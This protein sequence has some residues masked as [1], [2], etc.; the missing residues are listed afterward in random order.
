MNN[1]SASLPKLVLFSLTATLSAGAAVGAG[2]TYSSSLSDVEVHWNVEALDDLLTKPNE[3]AP[4]TIM[5]FNGSADERI[6]RDLIA[7]VVQ[8]TT[9]SSESK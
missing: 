8:E 4:G 1:R 5:I 2:F 3:F 7:Y 6:R 9:A